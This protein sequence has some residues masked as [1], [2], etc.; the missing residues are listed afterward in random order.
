[1]L[2]RMFSS[3]CDANVFAS[4]H[5]HRGAEIHSRIGRHNVSVKTSR[6]AC[7]NIPIAADASQELTNGAM[8]D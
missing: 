3:L 5:I 6:S 8:R 4:R 7:Q 2:Q 1:M